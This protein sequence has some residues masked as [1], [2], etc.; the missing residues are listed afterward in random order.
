[1]T[2]LCRDCLSVNGPITRPAKGAPHCGLCQSTRVLIHDEL[3][4]L[5]VAHLDCDAFY[6]AVEKRDNPELQHRPV[7]IGG[8]QRGVV[9]TACYVARLHGV[10]SAMPM[11][12]ALARCPDAVVIKPNMAKY[13]ET[14]RAI[15][16][17]MQAISPAV[18]PLS[19]DE[20][21]IDL[22]GTERLHN[23]MP[24]ATLAKLCQDIEAKHG[25][26]VSI[27]LSH[28]KF[29]AKL[30]S[31]QDKP[32]GF[33]IIG[34]EETEDYLAPLPVS[35][36]WGVGKR[37]NEKLV[38]DGFHTLADLRASDTANLTVKYGK[39]GARLYDLAWGRD[40]RMVKPERDTKSV[41]AETTFNHDISDHKT[42]SSLLWQLCEKVARRLR[43]QE[44]EGRTVVLKLKT[45]DFK[46]RTRS[47]TQPVNIRTA[48][49]MYQAAHPMLYAQA[50]GTP[51]RLLGVGLD[52]SDDPNNAGEDTDLFGDMK[53]YDPASQLEEKRR[54]LEDL[55]AG[56]RHKLGDT[57]V[58]KGRSLDNSQGKK[59]R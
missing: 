13:A 14:G 3:A 41:S 33:T 51:Y 36:I 56:L 2:T 30:A 11:F 43:D 34:A 23:S 39:M 49:G 31:E 9:A 20:A 53:D 45:A 19:I 35:A 40:S 24:A 1:M 55:M 42:L 12:K 21:F 46:I 8:G 18:E 28:N 6:A 5:A 57:A 44:L 27:G 38:K 58:Q 17:M 29:L 25:I 37:M 10:K 7:I 32:R 48:E 50:D 15:R 54:N 4:D 26:T 16:T 52:V 59:K 47:Q 22:H